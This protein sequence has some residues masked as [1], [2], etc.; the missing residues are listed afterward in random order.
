MTA[1]NNVTDLSRF[2][3]FDWNEWER[4]TIEK[5]VALYCRNNHVGRN[6]KSATLKKDIC[7]ECN[8]LLEYSLQRIDK[9]QFG[10]HKSNCSDCTV[11]CFK[12]E[13]REAVKKAMRYSGPRMIFNYPFTAIVYIYRKKRS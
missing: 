10:I 8:S 12:P 3:K 5:M 9:C 6:I 1:K 13:M 2:F 4:R 7:E 11:H